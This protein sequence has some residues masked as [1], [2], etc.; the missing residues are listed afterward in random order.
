LC[1]YIISFPI[2]VAEAAAW[3]RNITETR[4]HDKS[5]SAENEEFPVHQ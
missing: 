1:D 4:R 5:Q 2:M 3:R